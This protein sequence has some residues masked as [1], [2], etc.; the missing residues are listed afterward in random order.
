MPQQRCPRCRKVITYMA[1]TGDLIHNC[2][3]GDKFRDEEDIVNISSRQ[4]NMQGVTNE[5]GV[6]ARIEG[7][8]IDAETVRG[9]RKATHTTRAHQEYIKLDK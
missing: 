4:W 3:S 7:H 1:N 2:D 6:I 5:A 9:N 8:N